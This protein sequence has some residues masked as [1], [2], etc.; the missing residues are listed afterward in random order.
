MNYY[1][2]INQPLFFE[3]L[4]ESKNCHDPVSH[5]SPPSFLH[6]MLGIVQ[7]FHDEM[8]KYWPQ[9]VGNWVN[10]SLARKSDN[11][12]MKFQ[13]LDCV[14]LLNSIYLFEDNFGNA[15]NFEMVPFLNCLKSF[16][17]IR[18]ICSVKSLEIDLESASRSIEKFKN[19]CKVIFEDYN[20]NA[21][22]KLHE[23]FCHLLEWLEFFKIG[24]GFVSEQTGESLH[25]DFD[26]YSKRKQIVNISH[27]NFLTNL[28][29]NVVAYNS[30]HA[31]R[32]N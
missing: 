24:L 30:S 4:E 10:S 9:E 19:D 17:E 28:K 32:C 2:V 18:I 5:H 26:E 29:R 14:K 3:T 13:G 7:L 16:N 22:N 12:K 6:Y 27:P 11:P 8:E 31:K 21:I 15:R 20:V 1:N 25:S 23:C